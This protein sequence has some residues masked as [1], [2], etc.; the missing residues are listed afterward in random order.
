MSRFLRIF[1]F[2]FLMSVCSVHAE[3]RTDEVRRF[4]NTTGEKIIK[5]IGSDDI[6][7]KYDT[8][9]E[10]FETDVNTEYM[11]RNSLGRYYRQL[12]TGEQAEYHDLFNRYV[13]SIYKSYPL[14]FNPEDI[15]FEILS[16]TD[17]G[18][19][20][21]AD[22]SITLPP[23]LQAE[24]FKNVRVVFVVEPKPRGGFWVNDLQIAEIS[25]LITLKN[26]FMTMIKE[27]EEEMDWF[28]DDLRTL[29]VSNEKQL[30]IGK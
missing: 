15:H 1:F 10:I 2:I 12:N 3:S 14:E 5:T 4:L 19:Y 6:D 21:N 26:K 16:V 8:L 11:A 29:V 22:V 18:K 25:M 23:E 20:I 27:D 30:E 13:K 24:A 7:T 17:N 28:L 9:D